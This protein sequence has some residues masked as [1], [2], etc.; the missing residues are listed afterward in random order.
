MMNTLAVFRSR[1]DALLIYR[2]MEKRGIA[3]V[4]VSTPARLHLGCGLSVL[5]DGSYSETV[6]NIISSAGVTNFYGFVPK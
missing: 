2:Q 3:A 6:R 5:F 4:T 1:G